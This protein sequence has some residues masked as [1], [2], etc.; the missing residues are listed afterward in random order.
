[1]AVFDPTKITRPDP[2]LLSYYLII[3][4][5]TVLGFPFVFLPLLF[6]YRTLKY[7]FD[8]KGVSMSWG[9]MFHREIYL[10]YR[11]IQD[12]HV[13]RNIVHRWLGLASVAIQTASGSSGAEMTI[14]GI[15]NPEELRDYLYAQMRGARGDDADVS[16]EDVSGDRPQDE[17]LALLQEIRDELRMM[18]ATG[19]EGEA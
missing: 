8:D 13:S 6:K 5:S 11:R 18:Q 15:R 12:I 1:V 19:P 17:A 14:E 4:A 16:E 3:A 2:S 10:T 7:R 9:M